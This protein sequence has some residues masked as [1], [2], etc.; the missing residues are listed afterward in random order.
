MYKGTAC[1]RLATSERRRRY[2]T[3][4]TEAECARVRPFLLRPA[5]R[6]GDGPGVD[7]REVLNAIRS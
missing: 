3:G 6:G 4:L 2:P 7:R 1:A 5:R